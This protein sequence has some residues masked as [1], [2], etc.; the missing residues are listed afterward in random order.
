MTSTS[1]DDVIC[2][3]KTINRKRTSVHRIETNGNTKQMKVFYILTIGATRGWEGIT[4]PGVGG[5]RSESYATKKT[6]ISG[7]ISSE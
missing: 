2:A 6:K 4:F 5:W 7:Y 1:S 3:D